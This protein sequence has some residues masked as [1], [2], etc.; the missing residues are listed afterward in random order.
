MDVEMTHKLAVTVNRQLKTAADVIAVTEEV[1]NYRT[2]CEFLQEQLRAALGS[3][4]N[5]GGP[6]PPDHAMKVLKVLES[7]ISDLDKL[8]TSTLETPLAPPQG[9]TKVGKTS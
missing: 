2:V 5:P 1:R 4:D 3:E 9:K 7:T 8:T 6:V